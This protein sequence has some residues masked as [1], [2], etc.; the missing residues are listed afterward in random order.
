MNDLHATV[1]GHTAQ[2]AAAEGLLLDVWVLARTVG[3]A[4]DDAVASS[5]LVAREFVLY[6]ML[7]ELGATTPTDL[8]RRTGVPATTISK[9][10]RRM[11]ERSHL[12]E[13]D[14][15]EDARSRL[16]M[17]TEDGVAT[18]RTAEKGFAALASS[19]GSALG[20][21]T[22][23]IEWSLA[24]LAVTLRRL[25]GEDATDMARRPDPATAHGVH[26]V[27]RRLSDE[28]TEQVHTFI[29]FLRQRTDGH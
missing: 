22:T 6:A 2:T 5:G 26:Y 25:A 13:A 29:D 9:M 15:P 8:A 23:Q 18:L 1:S 28:E 3:A 24:R 12:R 4:M 21:E 16:L 27:G 19:V 20:E 17:L 11:V 10:L 7:D 14:N